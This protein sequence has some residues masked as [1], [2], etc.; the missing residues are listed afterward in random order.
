[1]RERGVSAPLVFVLFGEGLCLALWW[2]SL[3]YFYIGCSFSVSS[4]CFCSGLGSPI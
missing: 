3:I 4:C 1:M 2:V